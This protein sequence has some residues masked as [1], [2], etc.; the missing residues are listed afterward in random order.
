[1]TVEIMSTFFTLV[2]NGT[3]VVCPWYQDGLVAR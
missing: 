1:M 3:A 2:G